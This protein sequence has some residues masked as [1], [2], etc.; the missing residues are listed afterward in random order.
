MN[1]QRQR[2]AAKTNQNGNNNN[3]NSNSNQ[4]IQRNN[5]TNNANNNATT[6]IN[7]VANNTRQSNQPPPNIPTDQ[8]VGPRGRGGAGTGLR[9]A[10]SSAEN[11]ENNSDKV[12]NNNSDNVN[13]NNR[14]KNLSNNYAVALHTANL[15]A[16]NR[17]HPRQKD[18]RMGIYFYNSCYSCYY[19]N[20]LHYYYYLC[21]DYSFNYS[22]KVSDLLGV[23][24]KGWITQDKFN[25]VLQ[26][27]LF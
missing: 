20:L 11:Y 8:P 5:N 7:S 19:N 3:D 27:I 18:V 4:N 15:I 26:G 13:S 14:N 24:N 16:E 1:S 17:S 25:E 22:S 10:S 9:S 6:S 12:H 21:C 2:N 23:L